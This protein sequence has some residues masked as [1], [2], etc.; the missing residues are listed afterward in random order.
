MIL[1]VKADLLRFNSFEVDQISVLIHPRFMSPGKADIFVHV[2]R[3]N[4]LSKPGIKP[5]FRPTPVILVNTFQ[6]TTSLVMFTA[7]LL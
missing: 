1:S 4:A 5:N 2:L 3:S 6:Q 7:F